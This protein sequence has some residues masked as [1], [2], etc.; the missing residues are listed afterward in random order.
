MGDQPINPFEQAPVI[1]PQFIP[2]P[3]SPDPGKTKHLQG[4]IDRASLT[5]ATKDLYKTQ[6]AAERIMEFYGLIP[7]NPKDPRMPFNCNNEAAWDRM[8]VGSKDIY[9]QVLNPYNGNMEM[10][11]WIPKEQQK[12]VLRAYC[13]VYQLGIIHNVGTMLLKV[14]PNPPSQLKAKVNP[15]NG[16]GMPKDQFLDPNA[17]NAV[18]LKPE[19]DSISDVQTPTESRTESAA[20]VHA[21]TN[22]GQNSNDTWS[23][24]NWWQVD[25]K[26]ERWSI[27][28]QDVAWPTQLAGELAQ[29]I[30]AGQQQVVEL[31]PTYQVLVTKEDDLEFIQDQY[32]KVVTPLTGKTLPTNQYGKDPERLVG[33]ITEAVEQYVAKQTELA[34][35]QV[36]QV[37]QNQTIAE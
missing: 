37:E 8:R 30:Q 12:D 10:Q 5:D 3:F 17:N 28:A 24:E 13:T 7:Y 29:P 32:T 31:D 4:N 33:K 9:T 11:I 1:A 36:A 26:T 14:I 15:Y 6:N 34:Q 21:V 19:W 22:W 25:S 35:L 2:Q 20:V 27:S 16:F 18:I 23:A